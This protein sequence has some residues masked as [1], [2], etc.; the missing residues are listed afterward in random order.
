MNIITSKGRVWQIKTILPFEEVEYEVGD[1]K[2]RD[3]SQA[4]LGRANGLLFR[5]DTNNTWESQIFIVGNL[6]NDIL[7][8][9]VK[10]VANGK[11]YDF[12]EF[13]YQ[14]AKETCDVSLKSVKPWSSEHTFVS[15]HIQEMLD[16]ASS[17]VLMIPTCF[18]GVQQCFEHMGT[19]EEDDEDAEE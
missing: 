8:E 2:K 13:K 11:V 12:T 4:D 16:R 17:P 7:Q 18:G 1:E 5:L 3:Y 9:I 6:P 15:I 14:D 19:I 10:T